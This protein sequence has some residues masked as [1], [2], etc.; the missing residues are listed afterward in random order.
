VALAATVLVAAP[1]A[2]AASVVTLH[3]SDFNPTLSDTRSAGHEAFLDDGLA[4]WTDDDTGQ[5]KVAEYW[6]VG[7]Q[8]LPASVSMVWSGT[9]PQPGTQI[10]FD[11]DQTPGNGNDFN[12]LVGEPVY[13]DDF[14]LTSGSSTDAHGV[15]PETGG[16]FGSDCHGTLAQWRQAIQNADV[17]AYGFS[18]GSGIKGAGIIHSVSVD[19]TTYRFSDA[20]PAPTP[21]N[22][23]GHSWITKKVKT[24]RVV[25]KAHLRTDPLLPGTVRGARLHW[26]VKK[27]NRTV[28]NARV[29]ADQASNIKVRF[30]RFTGKHHV[31]VIANG[32]VDSQRTIRTGGVRGVA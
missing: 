30:K 6:N 27:D 5:A 18:L 25:A 28:F 12:I 4:V 7:E 15:C 23:T 19:E 13:G 9:Q 29:G 3:Q 16:G 1:A 32:V 11:F 20:S 22:V 26:V 8:N 17:K 14:W 2:Q 31:T 10:V 24:H 21:M